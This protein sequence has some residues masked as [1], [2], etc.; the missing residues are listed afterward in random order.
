METQK[1][2]EIEVQRYHLRNAYRDVNFSIMRKRNGEQHV[3]YGEKRYKR[4]LEYLYLSENNNLIYVID[5]D[6]YI[7]DNFKMEYTTEISV[8]T[9]HDIDVVLFKVWKK[10]HYARYLY[11]CNELYGPYSNASFFDAIHTPDKSFCIFK[12]QD[13]KKKYALIMEVKNDKVNSVIKFDINDNTDEVH[14][15]YRNNRI[16]YA[17]KDISGVLYNNEYYKRTSVYIP[18]ME[19][20]YSERYFCLKLEDLSDIENT[21]VIYIDGDKKF[22][23]HESDIIR[24]IKKSKLNITDEAI[25][26]MFYTLECFTDEFKV[27]FIHIPPRNDT[28]PDED[29]TIMLINDKL[30]GPFIN[31]QIDYIGKDKIRGRFIYN[32]EKEYLCFASCP[33]D[34]KS[35]IESRNFKDKVKISSYCVFEYNIGDDR[36]KYHLV[37]GLEYER[38]IGENTIPG[39]NLVVPINALYI[40]QAAYAV[41]LSSTLPLQMRQDKVNFISVKTGIN[42]YKIKNYVE[43]KE[44]T[45]FLSEIIK[46]PSY[47]ESDN[48]D[49]APD[50]HYKINDPKYKRKISIRINDKLFYTEATLVSI[51]LIDDEYYFFINASNIYYL[52][53]NKGKVINISELVNR[54]IPEYNIEKIDNMC[55]L[56]NGKMIAFAYTKSDND[57]LVLRITNSNIEILYHFRAVFGYD[58]YNRSAMR[59]SDTLTK[60]YSNL[61]YCYIGGIYNKNNLMKRKLSDN[62]IC[63]TYCVRID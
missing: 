42:Y 18:D 39:N 20:N 37:D 2:K 38:Y 17:A 27:V 49:K 31:I 53:T 24:R 33:E 7:N 29:L 46:P 40:N 56:R 63:T 36:L 13:T 28:G 45:P 54:N 19:R 5:S 8:Y 59:I 44:I 16:I 55:V 6:L 50:I 35:P 10:S 15:N 21:K 43:I 61:D 3:V 41:Y 22:T 60:V 52:T 12:V 4:H 23:I 25:I 57:C 11:A 47:L 58:V 62:E 30:F 48:F 14:F 1:N 26:Y 32:Y 51:S 34:N 9:S